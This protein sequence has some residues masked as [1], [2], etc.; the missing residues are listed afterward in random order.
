[1]EPAQG[2]SFVFKPDLKQVSDLICNTWARP[3][4]NYDTGLLELHIMRPTGDPE[5]TVGQV[6]E[7]GRLASFQAYMPFEVEY[8]GDRYKAVFASFLTVSSDFHGKG[9]AGPQQGMLIEKA[10]EKGYD[11]YITM[12]EVGAASNRAVEKIFA[13][14]NLPVQV[15]NVLQYTAAL[16]ELVEPVL[17]KEATGKTRLYTKNDKPNIIGLVK[18]LGA[19]APL[20]KIIPEA[21]I[22]FLFADRPHTRTWVFDD[23]GTIRGLAN[24][25]LLE[26]IEPDESRALNVYFDNVS[27]GDLDEDEQAAFIGDIMLALQETDYNTAFMPKIG[28]VPEE[29]FR[30]YRFRVAPRQV[31]LYISPLKE[32]VLP[33]GIREVDSFY[34]D[35]Y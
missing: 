23:N 28:Y 11:L 20:R 19:D 16:R 13:K 30:K 6:S 31:N 25:L 27:F 15:V 29:P 9:L 1:M 21:D 4:W 3:C 2:F 12:C 26:V 34:L 18:D 14:K 5:L 35:V 7:D 8:Y 17:P 10:I 24:L 33:K 32:G 22:D